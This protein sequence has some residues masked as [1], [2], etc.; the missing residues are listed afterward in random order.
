MK[1]K[2][3]ILVLDDDSDICTMLSLVLGTKGY[4]VLTAQDGP[5]AMVLL[6]QNVVDLLIMDML[7]SGSNGT[8]ICRELKE[9]PKTANLPVLMFSAHPLGRKACLD[10]G[11]DDYMT[12]PFELEEMLE[13][14]RRMTGEK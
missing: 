10:A 1:Q 7:L 11:A 14:V 6:G 12:K 9:D 3:L 8:D 5:K 2:P 4:T 13:K